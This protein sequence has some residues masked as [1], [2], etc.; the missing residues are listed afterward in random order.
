MRITEPMTMMTDYVMGALAFVLAMRIVGDAAAG[1]QISGRLWAAALVMTAVAAFLGGTYHGFIQWLPGASGRALWKATLLAT[2]IG[3]ACLLAAAV[4]AAT[5]GALQR[6]L[7]A[8]VVVKLLVYV[9]TIA[10]KDQFA[11]VIAD[12]GTALLAV[13]LAAWFIRPS[14]LT[15]AAWWITGGVAVAAVAGA[16]QWARLAPHVHF[17]HNDLFHVVQ[18][19]SLYLLYRGGLLL[20]DMQ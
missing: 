9:W 8:V 13:A 14:G 1:R 6:A 12:Y 18:M 15:P 4:T 17:N 20:R 16:I 5:A 3:S 19:A 2:G 11:L 7:L 10:T